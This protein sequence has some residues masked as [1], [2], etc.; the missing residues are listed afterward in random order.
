MTDHNIA[1]IDVHEL[2]NRL[3]KNSELLV[4]DVRE[5]HEWQEGH[6]PSA[7]HVPKDELSRHMASITTDKQQPIYLYC[8][9]GVRSL[10]AAHALMD[11]GYQNVYSINGGIMDWVHS[12][13]PI[14]V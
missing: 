3:A 10:Y 13:Y 12:G 9:G 14:S 2:K 6:L 7:R 1:T 8:K 5:A 11:I 4:I